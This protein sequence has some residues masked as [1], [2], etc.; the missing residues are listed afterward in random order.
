M[1]LTTQETLYRPHPIHRFYAWLDRSA[2]PAWLF[3]LLL[4]LVPAA[5]QHLVAW[6]RGSLMLGEVHFFLAVSS[7]WLVETLFFLHWMQ[8]NAGGIF[9]Q[10]RP[11]LGQDDARI[12]QERYRFT[13]IPLGWG[14]LSF[15]LGA[16]MG[17]ILSYSSR[18]VSPA[19]HYQLPV[20]AYALWI[21]PIGFVFM[22]LYQLVKQLR[23]VAALYRMMEKLDLY[24]LTPIYAF[25]R[26]TSAMAFFLFL[27]VFVTGFVFDPASMRSGLIATQTYF[28]MTFSLAVFYLPLR[29]INR[30]I[31]EEKE[32]LLQDVNARIERMFARLH[33]AEEEQDYENVS[34]M[35]NLL[36]AL[37]EEKE[38]ISAIPTWPW[39]PGT[40]TALLSALLLP[41]VIGL[42]QNLAAR[43]LQL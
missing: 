19:I 23:Q 3:Y 27:M 32:R 5:I 40:F 6:Q 17:G 28:W 25:A 24:D 1:S 42:L 39:K 4:L 7:I 33:R 21:L 37:K 18:Q 36:S 38:I 43:L 15:L 16:I 14:N 29:G 13:H 2:F 35:R 31:V 8:R 41:V 10:Y 12:A 9:D 20:L 22:L 11:M 26:Y 34:G 30:R